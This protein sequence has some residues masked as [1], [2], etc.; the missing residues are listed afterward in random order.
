[1]M[2]IMMNMN[3]MRLSRLCYAIHE[4]LFASSTSETHNW[5][6][7]IYRVYTEELKELDRISRISSNLPRPLATPFYLHFNVILE[8]N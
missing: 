3:M 2:N 1:M 4:N 8:Q 7:D 5:P 6:A